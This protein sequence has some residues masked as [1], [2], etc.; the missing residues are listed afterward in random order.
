MFH[1]FILVVNYIFN[2]TFHLPDL[3]F[4]ILFFRLEVGLCV[5]DE[6]LAGHLPPPACPPLSVGSRHVAGQ[7]R[8]VPP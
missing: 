7:P 8:F 5:W 1:R 6:A 3:L 2:S 4:F